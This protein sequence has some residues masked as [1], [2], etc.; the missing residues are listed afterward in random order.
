[1]QSNSPAVITPRGC[2]NSREDPGSALTGYGTGAEGGTPVG[3]LWPQVMGPAYRVA[4]EKRVC[5]AE[6]SPS[7]FKAL[8]RLEFTPHGRRDSTANSASIRAF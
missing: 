2:S 4:V 8:P 7:H 1:M 5:S 3:I 6:F